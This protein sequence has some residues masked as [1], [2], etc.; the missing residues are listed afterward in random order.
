MSRNHGKIGDS[1]VRIEKVIV[2]DSNFQT[3]GNLFDEFLKLRTLGNNHEAEKKLQ[4]AIDI[5]KQ[6]GG[7]DS[8]KAFS[9][10]KCLASHL[11]DSGQTLKA[12]ELYESLSRN[13]R[14]NKNPDTRKE[15][16]SLAGD[17]ARNFMKAGRPDRA[18][19]NY[20]FEIAYEE[21][22][23][24]DDGIWTPELAYTRQ[25]FA[26]CLMQ[27]G[28]SSQAEIQLEQAL[29]ELKQYHSS[30][31]YGMD[32]V[33]ILKDLAKAEQNQWKLLEAWKHGQEASAIETR[34]AKMHLDQKN[35][36]QISMPFTN[37]PVQIAANPM[38]WI[39][40]AES[41]FELSRKEIE[42]EVSHYGQN[43]KA[44]LT[45]TLNTSRVVA[46]GEVHSGSV[47]HRAYFAGLMRDLKT[48]G[49]THLALECPT[50]AQSVLNRVDNSFSPIATDDNKSSKSADEAVMQHLVK[51]RPDYH[52]LLSAAKEAG[53]KLIATDAPH[54]LQRSPFDFERDKSMANEISYVLNKQKD[55]KVL[56]WAGGLHTTK[57]DHSFGHASATELLHRRGY[58]VASILAQ[59][60][61]ED[62][63]VQCMG[64]YALTS[65]IKKPTV[66][67]MGQAKRTGEMRLFAFDPKSKFKDW[68]AV[69]VYPRY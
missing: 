2:V 9:Y 57:T 66:V 69:I 53:L 64:L 32:A 30:D 34:I 68:D 49:A 60:S 20:P 47:F 6:S 4:Q 41:G 27:L 45:D 22:C 63:K 65:T 33:P 24:K 14:T 5:E 31:T 10:Q 26:T 36:P 29:N 8:R 37:R 52:L 51:N 67:P 1:V 43:P 11:T 61:E 19:V 21:Q 62:S 58:P 18:E 16:N 40:L 17:A 35:E 23:S 44:F 7:A 42:G 13:G 50:S 46:I 55:A 38:R 54:V 12:A 39:K 28:K 48:A 3:S 59:P 56:F 15:S 25:S